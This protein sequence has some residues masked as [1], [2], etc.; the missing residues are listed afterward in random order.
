MKIKNDPAVWEGKVSASWLEGLTVRA[1][2][3]SGRSEIIRA[4]IIGEELAIY[5]DRSATHKALVA[6]LG[7][8]AA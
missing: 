5:P 2:A 1:F 4:E 8:N 6:A 3:I 7:L